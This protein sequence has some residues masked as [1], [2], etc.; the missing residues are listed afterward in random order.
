M[1]DRYLSSHEQIKRLREEWLKY[2]SL[3]VAYDFDNTVYDY[4]K[5]GD[6]FEKVIEQLQMLGHMGCTMI[7]F[8]SCDESRYKDIKEYLRSN[9]IPCHGIN[10][11]TDTVP[12][13]GRKIY[14]NVFYDDRAGLGQVY[15][16]M[17]EVIVDIR[18][19]VYNS[20]N[21]SLPLG[22]CVYSG[23]KFM[24]GEWQFEN[25]FPVA[26]TEHHEGDTLI[27]CIEKIWKGFSYV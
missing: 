8:T 18:E 14:Y 21:R 22:Q 6:T 17:D 24:R 16:V 26:F 15:N 23:K 1:Q 11:D 2:G 3:I 9:L 4:H 10:I 25:K 7:C 13:K 5:K 20:L 19:K 27:P 12:F